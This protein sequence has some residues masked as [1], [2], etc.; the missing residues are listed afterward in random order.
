MISNKIKK[1][2]ASKKTITVHL[3]LLIY[4]RRYIK[5]YLTVPSYCQMNPNF[6][7]FKIEPTHNFVCATSAPST[8]MSPGIVIGPN[9]SSLLPQ[10]AAVAFSEKPNGITKMFSNR[11]NSLSRQDTRCYANYCVTVKQ[12]SNSTFYRYLFIVAMG[13]QQKNLTKHQTARSLQRLKLQI[14]TTLISY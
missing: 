9:I 14:S 13:S 11:S 1:Y 7:Y 12:S 2:K 6:K 8:I 5:T 3:L 4:D 10:I